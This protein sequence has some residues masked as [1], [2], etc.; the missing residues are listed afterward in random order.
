MKSITIH[1]LDQ[2]LWALLKSRAESEGSSLN[3]TIKSLLEKALGITPADAQQ[4]K[5]VFREFCGVWKADDL[6]EF[7]QNVKDFGTI[8]EEDWV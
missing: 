1:G 8:D 2:P 7:T 6:K 3:K 5:T 4:K